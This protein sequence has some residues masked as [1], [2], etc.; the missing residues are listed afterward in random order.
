MSCSF[1]SCVMIFEHL[2]K[3][4]SQMIAFLIAPVCNAHASSALLKHFIFTSTGIQNLAYWRRSSLLKIY[5]WFS[6]FY[7]PQCLP[8]N[9]VFSTYSKN[10]FR[11]NKWIE[12]LI[13]KLKHV[14]KHYLQSYTYFKWKFLKHTCSFGCFINEFWIRMEKWLISQF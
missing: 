9:P 11:R 3:A 4:M 10:L 5:C 7:S 12:S 14:I 1:P 6:F 2:D 13:S 8:Y